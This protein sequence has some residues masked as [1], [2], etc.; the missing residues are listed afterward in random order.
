MPMGNRVNKLTYKILLIHKEGNEMKD[1]EE[2][3][4]T[5]SRTVLQTYAYKRLIGT[6]IDNFLQVNKQT[7]DKNKKRRSIS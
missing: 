6:S 7:R 3:K 4:R 1:K 2:K 5:R